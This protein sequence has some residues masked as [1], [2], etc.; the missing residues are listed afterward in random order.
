MTTEQEQRA[1]V[2]V[3]RGHGEERLRQAIMQGLVREDLQND[4]TEVLQRLEV[5]QRDLNRANEMLA[6][7]RKSYERFKRLFYDALRAKQREDDRKK[8]YENAKMASCVFVA[9]FVIVLLCM[10]IC[11]AI[12]G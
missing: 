2:T 6:S 1:T 8:R 7:E 11:R 9:M 5:M 12:F 4:V 3:I 10:A